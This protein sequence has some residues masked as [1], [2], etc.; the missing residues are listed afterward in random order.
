MINLTRWKL[1]GYVVAI[2]VTGGITGAGVALTIANQKAANPA[3]SLKVTQRLR[4]RL[5]KRLDLTPDQ[6]Q[7]IDPII[8]KLGIDINAVCSDTVQRLSALL[9]AAE[10][11]IAAAL[12][13]EQ[14][15]RLDAIHKKR[16]ALLIQPREKK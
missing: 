14:K 15:V 12:T 7:K 5:G 1:I 8:N 10:P 2:F 3:H 13:P 6:M 4:N 11:Q 16:H 9:D